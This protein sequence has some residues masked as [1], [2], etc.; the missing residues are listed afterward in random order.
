MDWARNITSRRSLVYLRFALKAAA[1]FGA[2]K[3]P[4]GGEFVALGANLASSFDAV[5]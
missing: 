3:D 4:E 1:F 2:G 5:A